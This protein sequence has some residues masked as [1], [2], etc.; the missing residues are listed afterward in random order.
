MTSDNT[1]WSNH[2][3]MVFDQ[4]FGVG[5]FGKPL[6]KNDKGSPPWI[7]YVVGTNRKG[8]SLP[9]QVICVFVES[10]KLWRANSSLKP[11]AFLRG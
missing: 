9:L 11:Q 1:F 7:D 5:F 10:L 3:L 2:S 8:K 6:S 4:R